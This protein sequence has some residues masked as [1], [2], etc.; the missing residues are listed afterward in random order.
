LE[1]DFASIVIDV[2]KSIGNRGEK[3]VSSLS[4]SKLLS[5]G[6]NENEGVRVL[7]YCVCTKLADGR[8]KGVSAEIKD[9][10]GMGRFSVANADWIWVGTGDLDSVRIGEFDATEDLVNV[11]TANIEDVRDFS[12]VSV[13]DF[14]GTG[15]GDWGLVGDFDGTGFGDWDLVGDF[16]GTGFGDW[17]LV[18][19]LEGVGFGDWDS[20]GDLEG[21]GAFKSDR[22]GD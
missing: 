2:S 22:F 7:E 13:G 5:E 19:D 11:G 6:D 17:D 1:S 3:V 21:V 15:F 20:V 18:G 9:E 10:T 12:V 4:L 14:D 8:F 16:D